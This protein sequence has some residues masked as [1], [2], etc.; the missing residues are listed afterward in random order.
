MRSL[1]LLLLAAAAAAGPELPDP[2]AARGE[3]RARLARHLGRDFALILGQPL[4]DVLQPRQE[5]D[6]LYLTGVDD[7]D[8]SL[9]LAGSKARPLVFPS[10]RGK[11]KTREVLFL[12]EAKSKFARF[13]GLRFLPGP[14][15]AEQ[16]GIGT[17]QPVPP[18]GAGLARTL[19]RVLPKRARLHLPPYRGRDHGLVR[20]IRREVV[21]ALRKSRADIKIVN[22]DRELTRMRSVKDDYEIDAVARAVAVTLGALRDALPRIRPD[23]SE[24]AVDGALL[25]GV[26]RRGALPAY[27]FV[28]A[29]GANATIPHYF[30]NEAPLRAGDLLLIDV[31]AAIDRYAADVTRTF[32]I[33][34]TFTPRQRQVYEAVLAAQRAGIAAVKPQATLQQVD[35]AARRVLKQH[36]LDRY[37]IHFI[38]HHVGLDVHDPGPREL[39]SGMT[40]TVEPGVYLPEEK[41]GI[42]IEDTVLVTEKG[43]RVLSSAFPKE[44][45]AI[46][47]LLAEARPGR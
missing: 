11:V 28:V 44:A 10:G 39:R 37:F 4:T 22:L 17:T 30:R 3:R 2:V 16:L 7:P 27:H 29:S 26:R 42:R 19:I 38:S 46:E 12:R 21:A 20:E 5:G 32:P 34:G 23:S 47:Q 43:A 9:L 40:I 24:A 36:G 8:A 13:F 33:S 35:A 25:F 45:A 15:S 41:L 1:A 6:F 14:E 31:G 18:G